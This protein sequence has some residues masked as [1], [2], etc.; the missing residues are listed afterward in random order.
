MGELY[1]VF[2]LRI[3]LGLGQHYLMKDNT[4]LNTEKDLLISKVQRIIIL[5]CNKYSP[6]LTFNIYTPGLNPAVSIFSILPLVLQV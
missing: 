6:A 2:H 4:T 1:Y 3:F 5:L